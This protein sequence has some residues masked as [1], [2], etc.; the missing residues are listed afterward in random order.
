MDKSSVFLAISYTRKMKVENAIRKYLESKGL[1]VIT[2]RDVTSGCNLC[3]EIINLIQK[4]D[5]GVVVYNELRHNI[6]YEWGLLDALKKNVILL[7]DENI[8]IDL[9]EELSD[10]KGI[11]FTPFYG[12]DIENEI[13]EQL[14]KDK[15]LERALENNIENRLSQY[16]T[17]DAK[18]ATELLVKSDL[19]L[20]EIS[21]SDSIKELPNSK[22]IIKSLEKIKN[23]TADGHII[24]GNAYY[25]DKKF[26]DAI[27]EYTAAIKLNPIDA[28]AYNNRG[29]TYKKIKKFDRAIEDYN[30]AIELEPKFAMAYNSRGIAYGAIKKFDRAIE[31]YN[32][33]I[34]LDSKFA[35]A[36]LN[37]AEAYIISNNHKNSLA[38][39]QKSLEILKNIK[40]IIVSKFLIVLILI[41]QGKG[42]TEEKELIDY[43]NLNKGYE[44]TFEFDMLKNALKNSEYSAR[45]NNLIELIEGNA[46]RNS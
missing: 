36:Y 31:D 24:K 19:Q 35:I 5:F 27:E 25:S 11:A 23:L 14:K 33:A 12:E 17:S 16:K 18:K 10:K 13:I 9:D 20:G 30:K 8:H 3:D 46:K 34:E 4:S 41:F 22:E 7:K 40:D 2:G 43:C 26:D 45:I 39:A 1:E 29:L 37:L 42:E 21:V 38:V 15:G 28:L 6:S 32:K 44:L